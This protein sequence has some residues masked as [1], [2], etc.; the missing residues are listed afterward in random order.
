MCGS[1]KP[2]SR[3]CFWCLEADGWRISTASLQGQ[4]WMAFSFHK[5][6]EGLPPEPNSQRRH[7]E[8]ALTPT[9]FSF[10]FLPPE[11]FSTCNQFLCCFFLL[12]LFLLPPTLSESFIAPSFRR[13]A[14]NRGR[15]RFV[16]SARVS[17]LKSKQFGRIEVSSAF[18]RGYL[19][20]GHVYGFER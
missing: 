10:P 5:P 8:F 3:R 2:N 14:R 20:I 19:E 17:I 1:A 9:P 6:G 18:L 16:E 12:P 4:N 15:K 7:R 11:I 13:I